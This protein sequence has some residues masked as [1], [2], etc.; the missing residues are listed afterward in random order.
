[1]IT[2]GID[3]H[4]DSY[5]LVAID[6]VGKRVAA[7]TVPARKAGHIRVLEWLDE[8]GMVKVAVEDCRH[9]TRALEASL[10]LAGHQVLRVHTRLMAGMRRSS[11]EPGKSDPIDAEAVARVAL[12]E[13]DLSTAHLAGP[14]RDLKLF[15]DHRKRLVEH[16]TGLQAKLRW[17][18]HELVPDLEV[19]SRGIRR[20][21]VF[22]QIAN[23]IAGI[24]GAVAEIAR[25]LLA[26]IITLTQRIT[27]IERQLTAIVRAEYPTILAVPGMGVLGAAAIVGETA[28]VSRFKSRDAFARFNGT[29]PIPVWS[30]NNVKVRL[31]RGGNR[32]I[33]TSLHMAAVTQQR[34]GGEGAVYFAKQVSAGKTR[35]EALRLLR[36]RISDRVFTALRQDEAARAT[37]EHRTP[38]TLNT[39]L[40]SILTPAA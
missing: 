2:A 35:A 22:D 31:S 26:D 37:T 12:R 15:S 25:D 30:G 3:A 5:T 23:A 19:P 33:N 17:F 11:R 21:T 1:M 7:L 6:E 20:T 28:G 32:R 8:F 9:L 40:K 10:L 14:E 24:D 27:A 36:R 39:T 4:K 13:D 38:I 18:L 29:A 16:R 34:L